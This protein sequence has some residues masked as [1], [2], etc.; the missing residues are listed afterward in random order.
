MVNTHLVTRLAADDRKAGTGVPATLGCS[1]IA[2]L[3]TPGMLVVNH[4]LLDLPLDLRIEGYQYDRYS[5][6]YP[7]SMSSH[8]H[9]SL[10]SDG[11]KFFR[12][13]PPVRERAVSWR[14]EKALCRALSK[15]VHKVWSEHLNA[16]EI[17][18]VKVQKLLGFYL[19]SLVAQARNL[20]ISRSYNYG[21]CGQVFWPVA[22]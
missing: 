13:K 4:W 18:H 14:L 22:S 9:R 12:M 2:P 16:L 15:V 8:V 19:V 20:Q 5:R 7:A 11:W 21:G 10:A 3:I 17:V 1:E 6:I